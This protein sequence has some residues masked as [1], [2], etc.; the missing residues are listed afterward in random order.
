M[1]SWSNCEV[2]LM[3]RCVWAIA[4]AINRWRPVTRPL[5][6]YLTRGWPPSM[7]PPWEA[8]MRGQCHWIKGSWSHK[9]TVNGISRPCDIWYRYGLLS[10]DNPI[11]RL[12]PKR[13]SIAV[14]FLFSPFCRFNLFWDVHPVLV[15]STGGWQWCHCAKDDASPL[16]TCQNV[17]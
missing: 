3:K 16:K 13:E 9:K 4:I 2:D 14:F 1:V 10:S 5:W 11:T 17:P 6:I 7:R 12:G 15:M 8:S